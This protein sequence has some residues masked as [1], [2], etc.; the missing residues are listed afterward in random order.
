MFTFPSICHCSLRPMMTVICAKRRDI[1]DDSKNRS[2]RSPRPDNLLRLR[3]V[4]IRHRIGFFVAPV[5]FLTNHPLSRS[6]QKNILKYRSAVC[7]PRHHT[8]ARLAS[9]VERIT[10]KL[11]VFPVKPP[12]R[13]S[14]KEF[15]NR[16]QIG[17]CSI[18]MEGAPFSRSNQDI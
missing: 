11:A 1:F 12:E 10:E 7:L 6:H 3:C 16:F 4:V 2:V 15:L 8:L 18:G 9:A 13:S 17:L 5:P 14:L